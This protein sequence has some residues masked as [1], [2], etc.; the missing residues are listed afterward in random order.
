M[1]R[2]LVLSLI[3]LAFLGICVSMIK[4]EVIFLRRTLIK[5]QSDINQITDDL[6]VYGAEWSYLNSPKRLTQLASKYLSEMRPTKYNQILSYSEFI[7]TEYEDRI[8]ERR[9]AL[10]SFLDSLM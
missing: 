6:G 8:M 7:N 5:I 2:N 9:K 1:N 4:Y 3:G 10:D